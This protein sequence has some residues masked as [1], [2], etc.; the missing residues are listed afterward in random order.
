MV[1]PKPRTCVYAC[2]RYWCLGQVAFL[3]KKADTSTLDLAVQKV[4]I[5]TKDHGSDTK[6]PGK[7]NGGGTAASSSRPG[8]ASCGRDTRQN[9]VNVITSSGIRVVDVHA[10]LATSSRLV[11]IFAQLSGLG[12]VVAIVSI[13]VVIVVVVV[14]RRHARNALATGNDGF[15]RER[16]RLSVVVKVGVNGVGGLLRAGFIGEHLQVDG[17]GIRGASGS[18]VVRVVVVVTIVVV[19]VTVVSIVFN[20]CIIEMIR[21]MNTVSTGDKEKGLPAIQPLQQ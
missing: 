20:F 3:G 1:L 18:N 6:Q 14:V 9:V 19:V 5:R 11:R 7:A 4:S 15:R 17:L 16:K 10:L 21:G 13:V 12:V 2:V 8:G